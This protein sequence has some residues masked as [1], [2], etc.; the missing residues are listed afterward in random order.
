MELPREK[1][2]LKKIIKEAIVFLN[3]Y[4]KVN[5]V[6]LFGSQLTGKATLHSDIDLAVISPD[7]KG[8]KFEEII[9]IF[10]E[11]AVKCSPQI[12]IKAYTPDDLKEARS[13]NFLGY[14]LKNGKTVYKTKKMSFGS[15]SK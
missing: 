7:F 10:A 13:T 4:I 12:E 8:K 1:A 2:A 11:L 5:Q 14:I 9:H 3:N 15:S 6:I